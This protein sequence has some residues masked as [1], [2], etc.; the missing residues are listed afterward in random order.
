MN[1]NDTIKKLTLLF[2][3]AIFLLV[4]ILTFGSAGDHLQATSDPR[5]A[6]SQDTVRPEIYG[7]GIDGSV[8]TVDSFTVWANVTD[9]DS[10]ILNVST[11]VRIDSNVLLTT[12]TLMSFNGTFY[13]QSF[14]ALEVNHTYSIWIEAYDTEIN[15][16]QSYNRLFDLHVY[17]NT[18]IDPSVTLPYVVSGSLVTLLV[19]VLLAREYHKRNPRA[20]T[21]PDD[22]FE[23]TQ[24]SELGETS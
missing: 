20:M 17:P 21:I 18:G 14:S 19:A 23:G 16:A 12:K 10:G 6:L 3:F 13:T 2:L 24:G 22:E 15:R 1:F 4:P 5:Y 7:W 9:R 8:N 11:V